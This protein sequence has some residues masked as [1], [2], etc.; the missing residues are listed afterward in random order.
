[1]PLGAHLIRLFL[2]T[3]SLPICLK[4]QLFFR[5]YKIKQIRLW[6]LRHSLKL[7]F[8]LSNYGGTHGGRVRKTTL[9][10]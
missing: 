3:I 8:G 5:Y 9:S 7:V 2:W 10:A 6:I 4:A 1:V